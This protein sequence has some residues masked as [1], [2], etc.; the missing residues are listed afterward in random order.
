VSDICAYYIL[1][2]EI[3]VPTAGGNYTI[4]VDWELSFSNKIQA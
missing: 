3:E 1:G 2:T 4:L